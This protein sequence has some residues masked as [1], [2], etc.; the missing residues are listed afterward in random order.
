MHTL[1]ELIT[2]VKPLDPSAGP[3]AQAHLD[4][5]TKP[6][7][8]LGR[9]EELARRLAEIRGSAQLA[10]PKAAVAVFAADHGVA[11]AGV[12]PY[13]AEVTPQM[14][15]NFLAGGAGINVLARHSGAQVR[16]VD[17]GV[18]YDFDDTPGLIKAK[19]A[20]GTKNLAQEPAMTLDEA[21][22]AI[23]AGAGVAAGLIAEGFDLLIPGDM[24]IGNTTP[25]AALT[26]VLCGQPVAAVTGRG[27][28]LDESGLVQ[29]IKIIEQALELHK[30]TAER[31][32]E[33]LAAV[34]GLEIAAICGYILEAAAQGVPVI[35]DGFI[36]G[37]GA[38]VASRLAPA[39]KDYLFAGHCS[40]EIGHQAQLAVLGLK[41]ILELNLR[42][43]EG[44]GAALAL[45]VL[46][47][48]VAIY[49]EMATFAAAG[50]TGHQS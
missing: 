36:A 26:A 43:G 32:L 10:Q 4:D 5:L 3:L 37:S 45:N 11:L 30:P 38:L 20:K 18:N 12:S 46:R 41:P 27:A 17:V 35:L 23:E 1:E 33:A 50:V 7:G 21:R 48:A 19:V 6:L 25:C 28:G 42:L 16:V 34:G 22:R 40:V 29:K 39:V 15:F 31:P 24:G 8:A 49:N 13:P 9:L 44:T 2:R 47:A 14:V